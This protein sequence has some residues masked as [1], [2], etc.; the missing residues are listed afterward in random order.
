LGIAG[1]KVGITGFNVLRFRTAGLAVF[2]FA[3]F[4]TAGFLAGFFLPVNF[5]VAGLFADLLALVADLRLRAGNL[6]ADFFVV[7]F[8]AAF[9]A[10]AMTTSDCVCGILVSGRF[11]S[12]AKFT[13]NPP[14]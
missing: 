9:F 14:H 11:I 5:R 12:S 6:R 2:F 7:F 4:L 3:A 13:L 8:F 1:V 10:F